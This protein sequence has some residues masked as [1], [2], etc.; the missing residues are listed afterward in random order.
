[1]PGILVEPKDCALV[2]VI[3]KPDLLSVWDQSIAKCF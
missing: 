3:I 1:M 2:L